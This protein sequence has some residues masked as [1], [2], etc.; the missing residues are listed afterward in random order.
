MMIPWQTCLLP[1]E[2]AIP[3]TWGITGSKPFTCHQPTK[4]VAEKNDVVIFGMPQNCG[5]TAVP[6]VVFSCHDNR[7]P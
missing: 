7:Y 2:S 4:V 5:K 6:W 3:N 1:V